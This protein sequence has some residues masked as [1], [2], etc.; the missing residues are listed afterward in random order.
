MGRIL[1]LTYFIVLNDTSES[2]VLAGHTFF[3][4]REFH[5]CK[6]DE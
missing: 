2:E 3:F 6:I 4:M 5:F 1:K